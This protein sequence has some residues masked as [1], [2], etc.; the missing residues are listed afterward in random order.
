MTLKP[1]LWMSIIALHDQRNRMSAY[2]LF[3]NKTSDFSPALPEPHTLY[4]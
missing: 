1:N 3:P 2:V 4:A